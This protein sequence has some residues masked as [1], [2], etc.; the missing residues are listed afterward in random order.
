MLWKLLF[1]TENEKQAQNCV[2]VTAMLNTAASK[3]SN[4]LNIFKFTIYTYINHVSKSVAF[5]M[6]N[7][8]AL[9]QS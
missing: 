3:L 4:E 5:P 9:L 2:V 7:F 1:A 6:H 8:L